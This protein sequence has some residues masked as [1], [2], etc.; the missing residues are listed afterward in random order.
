MATLSSGFDHARYLRHLIPAF[1]HPQEEVRQAAAGAAKWQEPFFAEPGLHRAAL[2]ASFEVADEAWE[3]LCYFDAQASLRFAHEQCSAEDETLR[4]FAKNC[5]R[6][7]SDDFVGSLRNADSTGHLQRWLEPVQALLEPVL[8][9]VKTSSDGPLPAVPNKPS[10]RPTPIW[11]QSAGAFRARFGD[12][13]R[14]WAELEMELWN[15]DWSGVPELARPK[16]VKMLADWPDAVV[17]ARAG[18]A[19]AAWNE[20]DALSELMRDPC[21]RVR[22]SARYAARTLTKGASAI[23]DVLWDQLPGLPGVAAHEALD[24]AVALSERYLWVPRCADI[25]AE[26]AHEDELR[27]RA[28]WT[29]DAGKARDEIAAN[30]RWLSRPAE[31]NWSLHSF[32][33]DSAHSLGLDCPDWSHLLDVDDLGLQVSLTDLVRS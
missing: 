1:E 7:L 10:P 18:Y 11:L 3:T 31:I 2:D 19:F 33:L 23:A 30:L 5:F 16:F 4:E 17:R 8:P 24:S 12:L 9:E 6:Y 26:P 22:V 21:W 14:P 27:I 13:D 15:P 25:L 32:L 20:I 28:L 29:L